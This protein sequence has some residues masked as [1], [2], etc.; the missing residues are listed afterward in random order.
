MTNATRPEAMLKAVHHHAIAA[1]S[2]AKQAVGIC[3]KPNVAQLY[4]RSIDK[5]KCIITSDQLWSREEGSGALGRH[6]REM[7]MQ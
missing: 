3:K 2:R 5:S 6:A 7:L 4:Q 1:P